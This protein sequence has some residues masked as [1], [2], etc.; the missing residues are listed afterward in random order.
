[1]GIAA[2]G[3]LSTIAQ[4]AAKIGEAAWARNSANHAFRQSLQL[5]KNQ[6][7]WEVQDLKAAGLNPILSANGGASA[8]SAF[9]SQTP[10]IDLAESASKGAQTA[11]AE[12]QKSLQDSQRVLNYAN[13]ANSIQGIEKMAQEMAE[14]RQRIATGQAQQGLFN[15]Q[16]AESMERSKNYKFLGPLYRAQANNQM[17][18]AG[19]NSAQATALGMQNQFWQKDPNAF[20]MRMKYGTGNMYGAFG[21]GLVD[22]GK[23]AN[24]GLGWLGQKTLDIFKGL[25]PSV[26]AA[27]ILGNN[28]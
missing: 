27:Q 8:G 14:M 6:H 22:A 18:Q 28:E 1:M 23:G 19:F 24:K 20:G 16:V 12:S 11:L 10:V 15:Q 9:M 17:A 26:N 3:V 25:T 13:S 2:A 5:P 7:Q 21:Q 4:A